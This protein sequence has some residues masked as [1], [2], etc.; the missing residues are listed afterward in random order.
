ME[1]NYNIALCP[2]GNK[3]DRISFFFQKLTV[4]A[5]SEANF[6]CKIHL[7]NLQMN[8]IYFTLLF[9]I[10]TLCPNL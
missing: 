1:N 7:R 6:L 9:P 10:E 3:Q 8:I 2:T 5:V 4:L